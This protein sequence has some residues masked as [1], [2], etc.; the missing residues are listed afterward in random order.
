MSNNFILNL[1]DYTITSSPQALTSAWNSRT[2]PTAE[3]TALDHKKSVTCKDLNKVL[4]FCWQHYG[5]GNF[6]I[7]IF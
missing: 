7:R 4:T 3:L 5:D 2:D 1:R 6:V